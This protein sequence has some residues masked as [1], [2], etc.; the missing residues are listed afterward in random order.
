MNNSGEVI[1]AI[2]IGIVVANFLLNTCRVVNT[3][4]LCKECLIILNNKALENKKM[5]IKMSCKKIYLLMLK[6]YCLTN[7]LT[8]GIKYGRKL[9]VIHQECGESSEEGQLS[10]Y[11]AKLYQR[12]N[13]HVEA[14]ELYEKALNIMIK[15]GDRR[16]ESVANGYLGTVFLSLGEYVKAKE[17][18]EKTLSI[19]IEIGDRKGAEAAYGN[20]GTVYA[21]LGEYINAQEY[22]EKALAISIERGDKMHQIVSYRNLGNVFL[23][24]GK[25]KE[26]KVYLEK[27]LSIS[28]EIG[29]RNGEGFLYSKLGI[30]LQSLGEYAKAKEVLEKSLAINKNIGDRNR[31]AIDYANLATVFRNVGEYVK[32]KE[33]LMKALVIARKIGDRDGEASACGNLGSGFRHLGDY[34]SAKENI[35]KALEIYFELG[36][37]KGKAEAYGS[38]GNVFLSLGKYDKAKEHLQKALELKKEI[39]DKEGEATI[40]G[41]LGI[42]FRYLGEYGKAAECHKNALSTFQD[43]GELEKEFQCLLNLTCDNFSDGNIEEALPSLFTSIQRCEDLRGFLGDSD[44][45]KLTFS[46]KH[47]FPY[48]ILSDLLCVSGNTN[49]AL[50]FSELGRARALADLISVRY[51]VFQEVPVKEL[52]SV[53][54]ETIMKKESNCTC[55]Y[56]SY[57]S[58]YIFLWLL[59]TSGEKHFRKLKVNDDVLQCQ[60]ARNLDELLGERFRLFCALS[61]EHCED[62]SLLPS[63][64][65]PSP[66]KLSQEE[67]LGAL[68][69]GKD[70]ESEGAIKMNLALCYKLIIAPVA[71]LLEES[72]I[73]IVPDR[74]LYKVPFAAL[75]DENGQYLS[76]IFKIRIVP[77]LTTLKLI[78]DSPAGYHSQTGALIVSNPDVG[79]VRYKGKIETVSRLP[80]AEKEAAMIGRLLDVQPL[81]GEQA[82]KQAVLERLNSVSLIHLAAHGDSDTGEIALAPKRPTSRRIPQEEDYLLKMSDISKVQLRAQLVVLSCCHSGRGQI[83]AEGVVGIARAFL[84]SGA[85]SVLVALWALEDSA[86]EQFMH[87]FYEHLFRGESASECLH[88]AMKWMRGNG[89]SDVTQWA[90]FMLIGDNVTFD[91]KKQ[92]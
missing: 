22:F 27:G 23:H 7:D 90:P 67:T 61:E 75:P 89:F 42:A 79:R 52:T 1:Q 45:F 32:A 26:A 41:N 14:K 12:Q 86:T 88:E 65:M 20:L 69:L 3:I 18:F 53:A 92:M 36:N 38:L 35:E 48:W 25:Y 33:H 5:F 60:I 51:S 39:G 19:K 31:E 54:L 17:Y 15:T 63:N 9:L 76:D 62:R 30:V 87:R 4:A 29:D 85:R 28:I 6:T 44:Q 46:D 84:G 59:E 80:C 13:K 58:Q 66:A 81:L 24:L 16:G 78:Q 70:K 40:V 34:E 43:I 83:R 72:E 73:I 8:S 68:R 57:S 2:Y 55:L 37:R 21:H 91:F 11:L 10:I 77:S 49:E 47:V 82:T 71:D 74:S 50:Y 64:D 56:L